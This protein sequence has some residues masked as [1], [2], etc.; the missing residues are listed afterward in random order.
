MRWIFRLIGGVVVI[1]AIG[2]GALFFLPGE[3]IAAIA[4]DQITKATGR[5]VTLSGETRISLYPVLGV[6]TGAVEVANADWSDA[7]PMLRADSL[8]IG[9]KPAA[10][11]GGDIRI[12]GLEAVAP[13]I[14]L[15]R[16]ADGRVNWELGVAG[17]APSGQTSDGAAPAT[18]QR[19]SLTLDRA[20]VTGGRLVYTD[21]AAGTVEEVRDLDL[22]LRWPDYDGTADFEASFSRG[23]APVAVAGQLEQVGRFID[24]AVTALAV[25]LETDGGQVAFAGRGG[26][27]PQAQGRLDLD[28]ADTGAFLAALGMGVADLP[29]GLGK[30]VK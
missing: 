22:D 11:F 26:M 8:K 20:L 24:G 7:G 9:V 14:R 18:S 3:R 4:A 30:S 6:A 27:Q 19:L 13:E 28:L 15:E 1:A 21:H 10:L 29:E 2:V 5:K 25:T 17:V 16:A 12:T 23:G